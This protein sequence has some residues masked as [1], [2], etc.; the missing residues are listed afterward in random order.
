MNEMNPTCMFDLVND[1]PNALKLIL[2]PEGAQFVLSQG[3]TVQIQ[4]F[5]SECP[6]AMKQSVDENGQTHIS[7][8]PDKGT[9]ELFI[10]GRRIW[11][12]M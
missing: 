6:L 9:Y 10:K 8:W 1:G 11:D 4:L 2:E 7:F 12:L 5:G 3:E